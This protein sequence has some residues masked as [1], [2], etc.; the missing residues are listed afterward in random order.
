MDIIPDYLQDTLKEIANIVD[1]AVVSASPPVQEH[2]EQ[3]NTYLGEGRKMV[4]VAHSQGNLY[5]NIA[6]LGIDPQYIKGFGMVSVAN[7]DDYVAGGDPYTTI[8]E[9]LNHRQHSK[10]AG[11]LCNLGS[12]PFVVRERAVCVLSREIRLGVLLLALP[13]KNYRDVLPPKG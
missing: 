3:Y 10:Y 11:V 1:A 6:Y 7:P 12:Y 8:E 9:D 2:I 5:G 4:L 13:T